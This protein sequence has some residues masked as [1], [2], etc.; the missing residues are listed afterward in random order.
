[1]RLA[2]FA[3]AGSLLLTGGLRA[4]PQEPRTVHA[5]DTV[6]VPLPTLPADVDE[7]EVLLS[8]DGTLEHAVRLTRQM[9]PSGS[10][11]DVRVP[12]LPAERATFV[13]RV[14]DGERERELSRGPEVRIVSPAGHAGALTRSAG[15]LWTGVEAP[16][17]EP[18]PAGME[19]RE[20]SVRAAAFS[21]PLLPAPERRLAARPSPSTLRDASS[22]DAFPLAC[23]PA[24]ARRTV[25]S[26]LRN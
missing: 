19:G 11:V 1:M 13:V 17:E 3:L 15:E 24:S 26:P 5:G 25:S 18:S 7:L 2:A 4:A 16:P 20:E 14:G 9:S 12:D 8:F 21:A 10:S 6:G 22:P 23:R